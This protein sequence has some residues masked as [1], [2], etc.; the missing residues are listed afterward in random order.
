MSSFRPAVLDGVQLMIA[1]AGATGSGKTYSAMRIASGIAGEGN[2]FAVI[3]TENGRARHYSN[4]FK[5]DVAD[6]RA[7]FRP[8]TYLQKILEADDAKYPV[9]V[10]DSMSHEYAGEGGILDWQE[11]ELQR[12]AGDDYRKRE[13]CKM[14]A[15]IKPKMGHKT[16]MNRLLQVRS[17]IIF[18]LRAEPKTEIQKTPEGKTKIVD[19]GFMPICEKNF[20][21]EQTI[22]FMLYSE[23][24]GI[25]RKIKL[26][27]QH[28][29][30]F[31]D[32]KILDER[33]GELLRNWA[34]GGSKTT[35]FDEDLE[36]LKIRARDAAFGGE[37]SL[38]E[39]LKSLPPTD[40][41]KLLPFGKDFRAL[42]VEA[43][44]PKN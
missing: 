31:P 28:E 42:A 30:I 20:M 11:E 37:N 43:D 29:S 26:E 35:S 32:G 7:P 6:I 3:D 24:P 38:N 36:S 27:K 10:V 4:Q 22:S 17:H 12:M 21:Y 44:N 14:A 41:N 5:F 40:K 2:R 34:S 15:W 33:C 16:L 19:K 23:N 25:G 9:I 18:C 39:F 13:A 8:D 1:L